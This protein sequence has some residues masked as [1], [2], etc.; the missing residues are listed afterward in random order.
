MAVAW[1]VHGALVGMI[2]R[3]DRD[4]RMIFG[5]DPLMLAFTLGVALAAGLFFRLLPELGWPAGFALP[6]STLD[7]YTLS[8]YS[9]RR[10]SAMNESMPTAVFHILIALADR[11]RHG[12]SIM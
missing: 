9:C 6:I 4:F 11:N 7:N 2:L 3:S 5:L 8:R 1:F 12:Y 10:Y